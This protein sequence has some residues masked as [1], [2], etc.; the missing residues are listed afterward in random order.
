MAIPQ[1]LM[2]LEAFLELP[3]EEPALELVDG[4]VAHKVSPR[5]RHSTIQSRLV[6]RINAFARP[7]RLA[8]AFT[9]LRATWA[10]GSPV[11]DVSVYRWERIP[12]DDR[13]EIQNRFMTAPD[14]VIEIRSPEQ[15]RSSQQRRCR[16]YVERG[17]ELAVLVDDSDRTV[18]LFEPGGRASVRR[19]SDP[20]DLSPILPGFELTVEALFGALR[21]E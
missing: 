9:E 11:P 14:L 1:R 8:L 18:T 20:I 13:G 3:E 5:G 17:V 15:S 10:G 6:E 7:R 19:G 2:S 21:L 4:V 16:W 12:V